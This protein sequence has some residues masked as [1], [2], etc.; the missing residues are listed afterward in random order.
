MGSSQ[1]RSQALI[2]FLRDPMCDYLR[3]PFSL[4]HP[5]YKLVPRPPLANTGTETQRQEEKNKTKG[6][7]EIKG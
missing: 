7:G 1:A 5:L 6:L 2:R 4:E 3:S